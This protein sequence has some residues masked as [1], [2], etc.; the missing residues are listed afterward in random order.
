[1]QQLSVYLSLSH[2]VSYFLTCLFFKQVNFD[3]IKHNGKTHMGNCS[4]FHSDVIEKSSRL[5]RNT[6]LFTEW[7]MTFQRNTSPST[8]RIKGLRRDSHPSRQRQHILPRSYKPLA[9]WCCITS[10]R[11]GICIFHRMQLSKQHYAHVV[12]FMRFVGCS[13]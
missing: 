11:T 8:S 4:G 12:C 9:Q 2:T 5:G 1:M 6:V 3:P 7:F 13:L 10:Q